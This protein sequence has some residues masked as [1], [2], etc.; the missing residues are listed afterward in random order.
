MKILDFGGFFFIPRALLKSQIPVTTRGTQI[1]KNIVLCRSAAH[2]SLQQLRWHSK[3][4]Y[5][6]VY[7]DIGFLEVHV[8]AGQWEIGLDWKR[9]GLD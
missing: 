6:G 2:E 9:V 3:M 1:N 4:S 8:A 5:E 7:G